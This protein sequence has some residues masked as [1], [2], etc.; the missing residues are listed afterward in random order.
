MIFKSI[1]RAVIFSLLLLGSTS[2]GWG[3]HP[4]PEETQDTRR[5]TRRITHSDRDIV[6]RNHYNHYDNR[7]KLLLKHA[8]Y[9]INFLAPLIIVFASAYFAYLKGNEDKS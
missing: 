9:T 4:H 2:N 8:I 1:V 7:N 3:A 6:N 5:I